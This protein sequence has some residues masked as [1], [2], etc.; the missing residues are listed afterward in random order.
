MAKNENKG[1][2][3]KALVIVLA[4][5]ILVPALTLVIVYYSNVNFQYTVNRFMSGAPGAIGGYFEKKPSKEE[6]EQLK[7][8][9]ARYYITLEE[10]RLVDKLLL[11]RSEDNKLFNDL[12]IVLNSLNP[13]KMRDVSESIRRVDLKGSTFDRILEEIE[14]DQAS[15]IDSLVN[16]Y[17]SMK[18]SDA[19]EEI[20][21]TFN[22][23]ELTLDALPLVFD[24]LPLMVSAEYITHLDA[25]LQNKVMFHLP[26]IKKQQ[27]EKEIEGIRQRVVLSKETADIY[28]T[29]NTEELLQLIGN[30]EKHN[31][32]ELIHI[33]NNLTSEKG[34][35]ILSR[36]ADEELVLNIIE[37]LVEQERLNLSVVGKSKNLATAI[38]VYKNYDAKVKEMVDIYQKLPIADLAT[39][40]DSMLSQN[41]V[42]QRIQLINEG[43]IVFTQEQLIIDLLRNLK[44]NTIANLLGQLRTPRAIELTQKYVSN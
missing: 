38:Q 32:Q 43:D 19:V 4:A 25:D 15:G 22:S 11:I 9:I 28:N 16:Y 37:G 20:L 39:L 3:L 29:K 42:F 12:V 8:Q 18:T 35:Q 27:I 26:P 41:T 2:A 14:L 17:S 1:G 30:T 24:R 40:V 21:R 5:F 7:L 44:P 13:R 36:I 33:Y 6:N 34:G 31:L 23:G 10:D